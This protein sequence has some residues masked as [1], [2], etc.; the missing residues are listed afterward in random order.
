LAKLVDFFLGDG[1]PHSVNQL[2]V[3]SRGRR[4]R[5]QDDYRFPELYH[6][7]QLLRSLILVSYPPVVMQETSS[8]TTSTTTTTI[9]PP[10]MLFTKDSTYTPCTLSKVAQQLLLSGDKNE[11]LSR[12]L[13]LAGTRKKGKMVTD[14]VAHLSFENEAISRTFI[15]K[16]AS[17]LEDNDYDMVRPFFRTLMRL[18]VIDDSLKVKRIDW[19][20]NSFLSTIQSQ[21]RYWKITD[22]CI[23]HLIRMI[24]KS[25][26]VAKW[27]AE[28]NSQID[29]LLQ[30]LQQHSEPPYGGRDR[31][32]VMLHKP[33]QSQQQLFQQHSS[34]NYNSAYGLPTRRKFEFLEALKQGKELD[35]EGATDSDVDFTDR[36]LKEGEWVDCL[37]TSRQY[38][39]ARVIKVE[40]AKVFIHYD[41]WGDKWDEWLEMSHPRIRSI[42]T[43]TTKEQLADRGKPRKQSV[44][45]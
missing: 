44:S 14:I 20:M 5:M 21:T 12:V 37:D 15:A 18:T 7:I 27:M 45:N 9:F 36:V 11:F 33:T 6:F 40:G 19:L 35:Q 43:Q 30:W 8:T 25:T 13:P 26:D 39:C 10:T 32:D 34:N 16:I 41:G 1:S 23:E 42:G 38:L 24:K 22:F 2:P 4:I 29:P 31:N 17:G 28:H 3:D